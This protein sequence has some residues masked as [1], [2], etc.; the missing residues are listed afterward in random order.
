VRLSVATVGLIAW[1]RAT[2]IAACHRCS[3]MRCPHARLAHNL[4]KR[5]GSVGKSVGSHC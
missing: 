3:G 2:A 4:W 5:R 1:I